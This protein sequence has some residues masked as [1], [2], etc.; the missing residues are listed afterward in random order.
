MNPI[1]LQ[2]LLA[3]FDEGTFEGAADQLGISA[4]AVSQR[5]KALES[6][7]GRI[8]V[9][10][11]VPATP[12]EAGEVLAQA[13]RRMAL[14][15]AETDQQLGM[16]LNNIP[17]SIGVNADSL[18]TWFPTAMEEIAHIEG[19]SLRIRIED[20][21]HT[22]HLL[23]S[24]DVLGAVTRDKNPV[25]GCVV[26]P[27][28]EMTYYACATPA[29]KEKYSHGD[30]IDWA[31]I[32]GLRYGPNDA[33]QQK[34]FLRHQE[35]KIRNYSQIPSSEAFFAAVRVGLGWGM[36]PAN[37]AQACLDSGELVLLDDYT[38]HVP[39]YW[40][41]WRLESPILEKLSTAV[42]TAARTEIH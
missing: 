2:T 22:L 41:R 21:S 27:L 11:T 1:H 19:L 16:H 25:A 26:E 9:H 32:P 10:R 7:A 15:Q 28:G 42:I 17:L 24:G 14:L 3:V 20:E 40:Q 38:E 6:R 23:R 33:I 30:E 36:L 8:L 39:L 12:T 34:A 4:S 18:A 29:M 31:S 5:I 35:I 37:Q 13:A